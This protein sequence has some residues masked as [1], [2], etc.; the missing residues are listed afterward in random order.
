MRLIRKIDE[1]RKYVRERKNKKLIG[2]VPTMGYLHEG[3][4]SLIRKARRECDEVIVSI[5]VNPTQFGRGEDYHSYPRDLKRDIA[6]SEKEKVDVIFAPSVEEMYPEGYSTFVQ[7]EGRLSSVLE[8]ASR[9]GHFRGVCTV[10]V[11][12]FNIINPDI[13]FFGEKDFQQALIVKKMV[14]DLNIDTRIVLLPTVREEDGLAMSSRNSYFNEEERKAAIILYRSLK[15]AKEW[16]DQGERNSSRIIQKMKDFIAKEP[17][18]RID[19]I[20]IVD[21]KSLE[22]VEQVERGNLIALAVYIGKVRLIDNM[23]V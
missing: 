6:L 7:V 5:F 18:A 19:Y 10:L 11:K 3:H 15:K 8:G 1:M 21:S 13:S 9:P 16:I 22:E 14:E 4:L 23:R 17:L 20:A 12:L 2:F